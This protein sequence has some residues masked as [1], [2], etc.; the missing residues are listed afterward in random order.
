MG[1]FDA[2][3]AAAL[4]GRTVRLGQMVEMD[5]RTTPMR[6]WTGNR[7][8]TTNDS[9]LWYGVGN[10]GSIDNLEQ[11]IG[12]T[13]PQATFKL[14]G[15]PPD[16]ITL[17]CQ[18]ADEYA[19][20][21]IKVYLQFFGDG[22]ENLDASPWECFDNPY[23]IWFGIMSQL[24]ISREKDDQ[25]WTRAISLTADSLFV[26]RSRPSAGYYSDRDQQTRHPGDLFC[27]QVSDLQRKVVV[28]P[29][30]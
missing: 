10:L 25:G 20:R 19:N 4:K 7:H 28:W 8:V 15:V 6:V 27:N 5:F 23:P 26:G 22:G 29:D 16:A 9:K 17:A 3:I 2:T 30:Y 1:F 24:E 12:G 18:E 14:T 13:S 11:A 21:L